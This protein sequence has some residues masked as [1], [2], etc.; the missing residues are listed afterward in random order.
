MR[1]KNQAPGETRNETNAYH[2]QNIASQ[3]PK[4]SE[5]KLLEIC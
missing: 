4:E 5:K 2:D 3:A 1:K